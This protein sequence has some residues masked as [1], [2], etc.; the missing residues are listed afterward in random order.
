MVDEVEVYNKLK[1]LL[2]VALGN[3]EYMARLPGETPVTTFRTM[4]L[5]STSKILLLFLKASDML[6]GVGN[7]LPSS[8]IKDTLN[9]LW[10]NRLYWVKL[11]LYLLQSQHMLS[12]MIVMF[13]A[14]ITYF[15]LYLKLTEINVK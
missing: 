7:M 4:A 11:S 1:G 10:R 6:T 3:A 9:F 15:M 8:A 5:Q 2:R 12:Y 14:V 13:I